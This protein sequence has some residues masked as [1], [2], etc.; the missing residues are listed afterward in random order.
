MFTEEEKVLI[1]LLYEVLRLYQLKKKKLDECNIDGKYYAEIDKI[2]KYVLSLQEKID[3]FKSQYPKKVLIEQL[4]KQ[5]KDAQDKIIKLEAD[6]VKLEKLK[7]MPPGGPSIDHSFDKCKEIY[8]EIPI[9]DLVDDVNDWLA[10][11]NNQTNK[12]YV[13]VKY[14]NDKFKMAFEKD[15]KI[16]ELTRTYR[17]VNPSDKKQVELDE[18]GCEEEYDKHTIKGIDK[19]NVEKWLEDKKSVK[20]SQDKKVYE[21]YNNI[22]KCNETYK[23]YFI[24][25][26]KCDDVFSIVNL[27]LSK[28][29]E[30]I[31]W[32]KEPSSKTGP[33]K[34]YYGKVRNC[35]TK[36]YPYEYKKD[37]DSIVFKEFTEN[38]LLEDK[39]TTDET[40]KEL[41]L[42][43][44]YRFLR[45]ANVGSKWFHISPGDLK[46]FITTTKDM[47]PKLYDYLITNNHL[48]INCIEPNYGL[49][50]YMINIGG[51][52][53]AYPLFGKFNDGA[54]GGIYVVKLFLESTDPTVKKTI[55]PY[56]L[57]YKELKIYDELTK[58]IMPHIARGKRLALTCDSPGN[59]LLLNN[60]E[61]HAQASSITIFLYY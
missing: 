12:D 53:F 51:T 35:L 46:T 22:K 8:G 19:L 52:A 41:V 44:F 7:L 10:D 20:L 45:E 11:A 15:K 18:I 50:L 39:F 43:Q 31:K 13:D 37:V 38:L 54:N 56:Q 47:Q 28:E 23:G 49:E 1:P 33:H 48:N 25:N 4:Q 29:D 36:E 17:S 27:D 24:S 58:E 57:A 59:Y 6:I 30:I 3:K 34:E 9:H 14:C 2:N 5:I 16:H 60:L 40:D 32:L 55:K 42:A 61:I 21:A 26:A